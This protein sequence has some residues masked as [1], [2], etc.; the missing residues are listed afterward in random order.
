M[1][2]GRKDDQ[3]KPD[4]T[5]LPI[6]PVEN[7]VKVLD[8]GAQKYA[9]DNWQKVPDARRRYAAAALRHIMA[10]QKGERLD[11]E[12]GLPHLS[13]AVCCLLFLDHFDMEA[14]E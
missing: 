3:N 5:L 1:S 12:S 11:P 4:W 8:F 14:G 7:V 6:A 10:H 9:R 2:A 13:H